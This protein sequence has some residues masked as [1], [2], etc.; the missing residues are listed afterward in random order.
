MSSTIR[1]TPL[2]QAFGKLLELG[3]PFDKPAA[4]ASPKPDQ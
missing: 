4:A 2:L 1:P 3:V